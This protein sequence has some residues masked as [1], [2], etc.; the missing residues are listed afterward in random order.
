MRAYV[1][2]E[3]GG[4]EAL[5]AES[6]PDP[7]PGPGE[8]LVH[9]KA[10]GINHLDI[11]VRRGVPGHTF[12]LPL[13]PGNDVAGEVAGC[14]AGVRDL[15][16]GAPVVVAPGI[17]CGLCQACL[18]GR[19]HHCRSYGILGEHR[20]GGY[21]EL[22]CVPRANV[23]PKPEGLSFPEAAALG[24]AFL[25][26][27]HM[28][29]ARAELRPGET[30]LVQAAGSGVGSAAVQIARLWGATVIA[31]ASTDEKRA[32]ARALGAHHVLDSQSADL[33]R[34][35]KGL[36]EGRGVEVVFEHVGPA[37]WEQSV[38]AL[39]WQGRLVTCGATTGGEVPFNL[40]H[41]FFK[42]LSFLGSTMGS[43]GEFLEVLAHAGRGTLRPVVDRVLPLT[44]VHKAHALLE[45]RKVFGKLVLTP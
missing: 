25:T 4:P 3:H 31:T 30:V 8:V 15:A 40:R 24:L 19:D 29:V 41:L 2:R 18:S 20:N 42:S 9:V 39:A 44:E 28:L 7:S 35:V 38:R 11:W 32:R 34:A 43:K 14:G 5:L 17:S 27:W 10:C 37:T 22:L 33:A 21:A 16:A 6:L 26:A 13:I 23:M 12:P 45:D 36:T 1:V